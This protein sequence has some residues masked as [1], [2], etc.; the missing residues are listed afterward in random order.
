MQAA[1]MSAFSQ[2]PRP[3]PPPEI[4]PGIGTGLTPGFGEILKNW[5]NVLKALDKVNAYTAERA[6]ESAARLA[7]SCKAERPALF[8]ETLEGCEWQAHSR[9]RPP[10]EGVSS[11][12]WPSLSLSAAE[13]GSSSSTSA[14][15]GKAANGRSLGEP[16]LARWEAH[17]ARK[18][19]WALQA[20]I[21]VEWRQSIASGRAVVSD[22]AFEA[23]ETAMES[24]KGLSEDLQKQLS[25]EQEL[26]ARLRLARSV[27]C[28]EALSYFQQASVQEMA[29]ACFDA[30]HAEKRSAASSV[31]QMRRAEDVDAELRKKDT[32][33]ERLQGELELH[34]QRQQVAEEQL[35]S[36]VA[37][38]TAAAEVAAEALRISQE[39][40]KA[41]AGEAAEAKEQLQSTNQALGEATSQLNS[42]QAE[43]TD[44]KRQLGAMNQEVQHLRASSSQEAAAA[45]RKDL[46]ELSLQLARSQADTAEARTEARHHRSEA[47]RLQAAFAHGRKELE[48]VYGVLSGLEGSHQDTVKNLKGALRDREAAVAHLYHIL[49]QFREPL[50]PIASD[51]DLIRRSSA[52]LQASRSMPSLSSPARGP[53]PKS[54]A[55]AKDLEDKKRRWAAGWH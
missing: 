49:E 40:A 4:E 5:D 8:G 22:E 43:L 45:A 32:D 16:A 28:K 48:I 25:V 1:S 30:W 17:F 21:F 19:E 29:R 35:A 11:F 12:E 27:R 42:A 36:S 31:E 51:E 7:E 26:A 6:N 3:P 52:Q 55:F 10:Q 44:L 2:R 46:G 18:A 50:A 9:A 54:R 53:A 14:G 47:E 37:A 33:L 24:A 13:G 41:A 38:S 39:E 34:S 23:L 15:A 20:E